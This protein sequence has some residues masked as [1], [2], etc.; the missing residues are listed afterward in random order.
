MMNHSRAFRVTRPLRWLSGVQLR[1]KIMAGVVAVMLIAL[2]AFDIAAVTTMRHYLYG[3]TD[4]DLQVA[5]DST[6]G[7]LS[8]LVPGYPP[9]G[10]RK[11]QPPHIRHVTTPRVPLRPVFGGFIIVYLPRHGKQVTLQ[12][13]GGGPPSFAILPPN[14]V[15]AVINPGP[16]N[17]VASDGLTQMR[18]QG[19]AVRGGSL[20]A[21]PASAS[22]T[23][24]LS[25]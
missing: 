14:A 25:R 9:V 10:G 17:V 15:K 5:L 22:S 7:Q 20:V 3:Q 19:I 16:H 12:V 23:I 2:T 13:A 6:R 18:L 24:R 1:L 4:N 21:G 8:A 11:G